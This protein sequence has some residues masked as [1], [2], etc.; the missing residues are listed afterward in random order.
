MCPSDPKIESDVCGFGTGSGLGAALFP[1]IRRKALALFLLNPEKQFY[2]RQIIRLLGDTPGSVQRELKS[3][4]G[5]GILLMEPIGIHKFY[6]ANKASPVFGELKTI[7]ERTFGIADVIRDVLRSQ[8][9]GRLDV[10]WIYGSVASASD[11]GSSD[12]DLMVVGSVTFRELV[13]MLGPLE[14]IMQRPVNPNLYSKE[15][16]QKRVR[17]KNNFIK[18]VMDSEKLFVVGGQD[19]LNRLVQ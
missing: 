18:N 11:T 16:F 9:A 1:K 15:E 4:T 17:D 12:I 10:A 14:E 19:D 7:A 6:R 5:V 3:L 13:S 2:F 8:S